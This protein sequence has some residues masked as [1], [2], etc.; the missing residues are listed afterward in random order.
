MRRD[1]AA[2]I[3]ATILLTFQSTRLHEA[4]PSLNVLNGRGNSFQSTR[5]HEARPLGAVYDTYIWGFNPRA[6]MRRDFVD[7]AKYLVA[8]V[9]IHAPA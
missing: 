7:L 4:R 5:L 1:I 3:I 8:D 9:S 2:A 6:C